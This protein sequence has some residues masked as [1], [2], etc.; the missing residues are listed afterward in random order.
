ME[1]DL[2]D[3]RQHMCRLGTTHVVRGGGDYRGSGPEFF[4]GGGGQGP[5]PQDT[6]A[7]CARGSV[8]VFYAVFAGGVFNF[9]GKYKKIVIYR[10]RNQVNW[11]V[12]ARIH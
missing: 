4:K 5:G 10:N 6:V 1:G 8:L 12:Y 9:L 3:R 2:P 11:Q 7:V